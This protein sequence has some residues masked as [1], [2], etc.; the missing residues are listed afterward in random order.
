MGAEPVQVR[1]GQQRNGY[2]KFVHLRVRSVF[3][4]LEG[5]VKSKELAKLAREMHMPAVAVT[6]TN[7]LFGAYEISDTLAKSGIQPIVAVPL[8]VDF[9]AGGSPHQVQQVKS[10]PS[11]ALLVKDAAGYVQL[12]K[13]LSSAYLEVE[14]GELPHASAERLLSPAPG[15]ILLT[16]G[17]NGPIDRLLAEGQP[18][19]AEALLDRLAGAFGDRLFVGLPRHGPPKQAPVEEKLI[20]LAYAKNLPL[21]AT[22]DVHFGR[23]NMYEAHDTLLCIADC[24]F[25]D[26]EDRRRLTPE[27]RFKSAEEMAALFS[28]LPEAIENTLEIARRCAFKPKKRAP[29]LPQ[30]VPESGLPTADELRAQAEAGLKR[31]LAE[32]GLYADEKAYWD[33]LRY[34]LDVIITMGF[35]GY[36][37]IV[38]DFMKWTRANGIPVGVRGS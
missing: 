36:F 15:L 22:N 4:L 30:F 18:H 17:P 24:T 6:D 33:R 21:V 8:S 13:L 34:E 27:H 2:A 20:D 16:G 1:N 7:N 37:L 12:S 31:R 10:Y 19:A 25:L 29:I 23:E 14:S 3:S 35:P 9:D 32:H 11:V 5:A 38:S 28:D 26:V